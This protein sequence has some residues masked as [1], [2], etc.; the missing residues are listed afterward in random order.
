MIPSKIR[1]GDT[2]TWLDDP[3]VDSE[4]QAITSADYTL[5]YHLRGGVSLNIAAVADGLGWRT[6]LSAAN[7]TSLNKGRYYWAAR[8]TKVGQTVT[9]ANG[10]LDV[11]E[12]ISAQGLGYDGRSQPR[13][14][15]EAVQSA[16]RSIISGG[17]VAEYTIGNRSLR[18]LPMAD[19][20]SLESKLKA[21]VIREEKATSI[22]NGLGD[23]TSLYVRFSK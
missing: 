1:A 2:V 9:V 3:A 22:K 11:L 12:D 21:E 18:K 23:P 10:V 7:T 15:L 19:L 5:T 20:L 4:G 6:S 13:K 17:A 8:A 16:I 14:D